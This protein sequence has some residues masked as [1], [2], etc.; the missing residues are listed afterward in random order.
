MLE[1][2]NSI[3]PYAE[4]GVLASVGYG[5]LNFIS[6]YLKSKEP[7]DLN[8]MVYGVFTDLGWTVPFALVGLPPVTSAGLAKATNVIVSKMSEAPYFKGEVSDAYSHGQVIRTQNG[9]TFV[10]DKF[11][12]TGVTKED[13]LLLSENPFSHE[14]L[15]SMYGHYKNGA[16]IGTRGKIVYVWSDG[17]QKPIRRELFKKYGN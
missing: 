17:Y 3:F 9:V 4:A 8:K 1:F 16:E 7:F 15:N 10:Y 14:E 5:V 6:K 2:L 11:L 12:K 13:F